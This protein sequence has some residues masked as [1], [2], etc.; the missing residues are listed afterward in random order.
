M[1]IVVAVLLLV[2]FCV[3]P[4]VW[5]I[6]VSHRGYKETMAYWAKYNKEL[7]LP[8]ETPVPHGRSGWAPL[9][10]TRARC[11]KDLQEGKFKFPPRRSKET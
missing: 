11:L 5:F 2:I 6:V 8:P 1:N 7:G 10:S 4:L 9:P 3:A